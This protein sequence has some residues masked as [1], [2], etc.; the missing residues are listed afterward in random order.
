MSR[1]YWQYGQQDEE[2]RR[3][4]NTGDILCNGAVCKKCG[5]FI[6][7]NNRHDFVT[8]SCGNISVD[9]GSWYGKIVFKEPD[10]F[11]NVIVNYDDV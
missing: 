1:H 2:T 6:R 11:V 8:C 10:S 7:S 5:D 4:N 9:G 3:K